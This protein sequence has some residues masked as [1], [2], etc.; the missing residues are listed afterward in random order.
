MK[1][2]MLITIILTGMLFAFDFSEDTVVSAKL[3]E[4]IDSV[5]AHQNFPNASY[6]IISDSTVVSL[7][8]TGSETEKYFLAKAYTYR[9]KKRLSNFKIN[10]N[11]DYEEVQLIRARTI[12]DDG[13]FPVDT[14]EVNEITP[15]EYSE[16][17]QYVN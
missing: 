3:Q 16:A 11:A 8:P 15:P 2:I 14:M 4:L 17:T 5:P 10:Y 12:N 13:V 7:T 9:G 1:K 6:Y